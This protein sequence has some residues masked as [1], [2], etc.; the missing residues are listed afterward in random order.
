MLQHS[1]GSDTQKLAG[2]LRLYVGMDM[3]LTQSYL[4]PLIVRGTAVLVHD[5]Q[6]RPSETLDEHVRSMNRDGFVI[7]QFMPHAVC[8]RFNDGTQNILQGYDINKNDG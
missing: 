3:V 7:L 1:K 8:V 6:L 4:P 2:L 5:I